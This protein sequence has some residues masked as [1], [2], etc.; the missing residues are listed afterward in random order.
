MEVGRAATAVLEAIAE[1][2]LVLDPDHRIVALNRRARVLLGSEAAGLPIHDLHLSPPEEV[3]RYLDRCRGSSDGLLGMLML[4]KG[5]DAEKH[6]CRGARVQMPGGAGVMLT[7]DR[8]EEE[9]FVAL[10]RKVAELDA[11]I[12]ERRHA[13]AVLAEAL[14]ERDLL[15]RELQHRV[16]NN[17]HMLTAL[18][19]GAERET[20]SPEAKAVLRD[21]SQRFS[22]VSAV[23][24]LVYGASGLD[25]I[26]G[27][28]LVTA[29][30]RGAVTLAAREVSLAIEA[31]P[32]P[33]SIEPA[34]SVAL[35]VN[36]LV[37]NSAKYGHRAEAHQMITLSWAKEGSE[38]QL[39]VEDNGPGF[40]PP[41]GGRRASGLG[42]VRGL[43][44]QL[45]GSLQIQ[46]GGTENGAGARCVVRFPV[47]QT[48]RRPGAPA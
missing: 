16:K 28:E 25:E 18:L 24:Q 23:Q 5:D 35:I 10:S 37:T 19:Q 47:P 38:V 6:R 2:A 29:V 22:A 9:R 39:I 8:G 42:L 40:P 1:P 17:M 12:R 15:L 36:E 31:E 41:H 33:L 7:L 26:D 13:E 34:V 45:G 3:G 43:L 44:R 27:D 48:R 30:A 20:A 21:A 46:A 4:R 14:R 32:F 11:E